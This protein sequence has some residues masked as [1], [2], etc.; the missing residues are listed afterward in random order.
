MAKIFVSTVPFGEFDKTP[1]DLLKKSDLEFQINPL[2][3]KL[4]AQEVGEFAKDCDGLIAGTEDIHKVI[5]SAK[6]IKIVSRVGIGLDSVPLQECRDRGIKVCYTPDAVTMAVAEFTVGT[7]LSASRYI[8]NADRRLRT[9]NWHLFQGKRLG[10]SVIGIIG[11]GRVGSNVARLLSEFRPKT[12]LANDLIDKRTDIEALRSG[13]ML[14]IQQVEKE[15]IYRSADIISLHLPLSPQTKNLITAETFQHF[16][17][18]SF[19]I[20]TARG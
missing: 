12:I 17:T 8:V 1:I 13:K 10:E 16:R 4:S 11:F 3:R 18:D 14:D 7:M 9:G 15:E 19:L 2:N 5:Q 6:S 20:N